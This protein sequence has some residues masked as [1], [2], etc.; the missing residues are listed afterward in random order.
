[1]VVGVAATCVIFQ[2]GLPVNAL[3]TTIGAHFKAIPWAFPV[4]GMDR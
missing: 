4:F 1:M 2:L 3:L